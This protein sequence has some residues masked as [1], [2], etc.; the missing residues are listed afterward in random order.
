MAESPVP[1]DHETRR[2]AKRGSFT[3]GSEASQE[4]TGPQRL[5]DDGE[6]SEI[7]E[8]SR[9]TQAGGALKQRARRGLWFIL[10]IVVLG[11]AVLFMPESLRSRLGEQ[12][13]AASKW[14]SERI[15]APAPTPEPAAAPPSSDP[16]NAPTPS[17]ASPPQ[18]A[19]E[20]PPPA[21]DAVTE[22]AEQPPAPTPPPAGSR[23]KKRTASPGVRAAPA[24][25]PPPIQN[26]AR[27]QAPSESIEKAP[28][29]LEPSKE[30]S[31]GPA[32]VDPSVKPLELAPPSTEDG[33][34]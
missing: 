27:E 24:A 16:A 8:V 20:P 29:P 6:T 34:R 31:V 21:E 11:L 33:S 22:A 9:V 18:D 17:P 23:L 15:T 4:A 1:G 7:S 25:K 12:L 13:E 10:A 2:P 28:E 14:V 3:L 26:R 32:E 30:P 19:Y 5:E